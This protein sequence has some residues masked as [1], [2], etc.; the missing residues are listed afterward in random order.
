MATGFLRSDAVLEKTQKL[1]REFEFNDEQIDGEQQHQIGIRQKQ[2]QNQ[3]KWAAL[4]Y[5]H[6]IAVVEKKFKTLNDSAEKLFEIMASLCI[7]LLASNHLKEV[8]YQYRNMCT[9]SV[10]FMIKFLHL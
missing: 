9:N 4:D 10:I 3:S 1:A 7:D 8:M 5:A 6:K 2:D